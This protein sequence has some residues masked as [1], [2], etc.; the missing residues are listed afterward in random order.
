VLGYV[1]KASALRQKKTALVPAYSPL[2]R[3]QHSITAMSE[4]DVALAGLAILGAL[5]VILLVL[6]SPP[7]PK[8]FLSD[9][10]DSPWAVSLLD[11]R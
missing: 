1:G 4:H 7:D 6:R 5:D 10:Y 3:I 8:S 9:G 2:G 11:E